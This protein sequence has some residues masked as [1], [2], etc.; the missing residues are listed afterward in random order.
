[1]PLGPKW[2]LEDSEVRWN[3]YGGI[4]SNP[5]STVRGS[6]IHHNGGIGLLGSGEG[7]TIADNEISH[8]G[9]AGYNPFWGA[10]GAKWGMWGLRG[11]TACGEGMLSIGFVSSF[12]L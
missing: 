11:T 1:M 3:H 4:W 5:Q 2:V 10:G 12:F 6:R 9:F 7:I 8:N